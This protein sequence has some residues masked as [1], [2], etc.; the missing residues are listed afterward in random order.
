MSIVRLLA[1]GTRDDIARRLGVFAKATFNCGVGSE[2]FEPGNTCGAG[3]G[4][5]GAS[6]APKGKP[7]AGSKPPP[8]TAKGIE[9]RAKASGRSF[10]DQYLHESRSAIDR[11]HTARERKREKRVERAKA[12]VARID[13]A[14][15]KVKR[16]RAEYEA[17]YAEGKARREA[18]QRQAAEA[19]DADLAKRAAE[20]RKQREEAAAANAASKA[21]IE[22]I[23]R[24]LAESKARSRGLRT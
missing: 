20:A 4:G 11:D 21:R 16:E 2:G 10:T 14:I 19:R 12:E 8:I 23:K 17:A 18:E 7:R 15:E 6:E 3:G 24:Q 5:G 9:E 1:M 13:A 22:V